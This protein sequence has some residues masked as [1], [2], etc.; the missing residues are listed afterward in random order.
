MRYIFLT[1]FIV[2]LLYY[3][4]NII[5][6]L[7]LKKHPL[8]EID[9]A[10]ETFTL[11]SDIIANEEPTTSVEIDDVENL[12]TPSSFNSFHADVEEES[13]IPTDYDLA[14]LRDKFESGELLDSDFTSDRLDAAQTNIEEDTTLDIQHIL[15]EAESMVKVVDNL[16]GYKVYT[17]I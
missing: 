2:Y 7:F 1:I 8:L 6:D 5:Y 9:A 11:D 12:V 17:N 3:S 4:G 13:A 14:L 10:S 15:N 16:D